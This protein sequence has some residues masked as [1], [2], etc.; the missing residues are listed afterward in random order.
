MK[1]AASNR[2]WVW[3]LA[4]VLLLGCLWIY[5]DITA[6]GFIGLDDDYNVIFNSHLGPVTLKRVAW[7]FTDVEYSRRYQPLGWLGLASVFGLSGLG[8][9]GYHAAAIVFHAANSMLVFGGPAPVCRSRARTFAVALAGA[10]GLCRR[11]VLGVA[12]VARGIG[13]VGVGFAL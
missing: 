2:P 1:H 13:R 11:R 8:A 3:L 4:G 10:G 5:Q 9:G 12:S 7:A 6:F